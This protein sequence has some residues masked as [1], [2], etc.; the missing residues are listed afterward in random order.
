M[1]YYFVKERYPLERK[2][3]LVIQIDNSIALGRF[4]GKYW[5]VQPFKGAWYTTVRGIKSW[6]YV[7]DAVEF[8]KIGSDEIGRI[9]EG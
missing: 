8:Q 2:L 1:M 7:T 5:E 6:A 3:C 4:Y 9:H